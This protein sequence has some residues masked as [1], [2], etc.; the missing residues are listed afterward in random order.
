VDVAAVVVK[1]IALVNVGIVGDEEVF[2]IIY[3][4]AIF[5]I[6]NFNLVRK[7]LTADQLTDMALD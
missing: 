3:V 7:S 2:A 4:V 6:V 1:G 5:I